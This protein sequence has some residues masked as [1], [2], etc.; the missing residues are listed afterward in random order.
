M[1]KASFIT[2]LQAWSTLALTIVGLI[3]TGLQCRLAFKKRKDELFD[4]RYAFYL[5]IRAA[6]LY[7]QD[8]SQPEPDVIDWIPF[9]EEASFLFGDDVAKHIA[10]LADQRHTG[11]PFFP[12]ADFIKP[13]EKYLR[14]K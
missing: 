5:K 6:W 9:A 7:T 2:S 1:E 12:D 14:L 10:S 11:A 3:F 13:F 4:R 8:E